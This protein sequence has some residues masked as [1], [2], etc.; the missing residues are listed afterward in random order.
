MKLEAVNVKM[1]LDVDTLNM[2]ADVYKASGRLGERCRENLDQE[3]LQF[4]KSVATYAASTPRTELEDAQKRENFTVRMLNIG[5]FFRLSPLF[6]DAVFKGIVLRRKAVEMLAAAMFDLTLEKAFGLLGKWKEGKNAKGNDQLVKELQEKAEKEYFAE[7]MEDFTGKVAAAVKNAA[8]AVTKAKAELAEVT[9]KL[10]TARRNARHFELKIIEHPPGTPDGVQ[11][12]WYAKWSAYDDAATV[13]QGQQ[14]ELQ[15]VFISARKAA[16]GIDAV[17]KNLAQMADPGSRTLQSW[18]EAFAPGSPGEAL[19]QGIRENCQ[20]ELDQLADLYRAELAAWDSRI[21]NLPLRLQGP[22]REN[23]KKAQDIA[24]GLQRLDAFDAF[25]VDNGKNV[26]SQVLQQ[27]DQKLDEL[28][29]LAQ[30][31]EQLSKEQAGFCYWLWS[32]LWEGL[33]AVG[34]AVGRAVSAVGALLPDWLVTAGK[35]V[36][37]VTAVVT[38]IYYW[39][40]CLMVAGFFILLFLV[41][42]LFQYTAWIFAYLGR[43][44]DPTYLAGEYRAQGQKFMEGYGVPQA[45]FYG[46]MQEEAVKSIVFDADPDNLPEAAVRDKA[47]AQQLRADLFAKHQQQ[48]VRQADEAKDA[49]RAAVLKMCREAL[50]MPPILN[51]DKRALRQQDSAVRGVLGGVLAAMVS[52]ERE[53]MRSQ[54]GFVDFVARKADSLLAGEEDLSWASINQWLNLLGTQ[55]SLFLNGCCACAVRYAPDKVAP[56]V[57]KVAALSM[58]VAIARVLLSMLCVIPCVTAF[59]GDFMAMHGIAFQAMIRETE[60]VPPPDLSVTAPEGFPARLS[61]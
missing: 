34:N 61:G 18:Q 19:W 17:R 5:S 14:A 7:A 3:F 33:A 55:V 59:A 16:E 21:S 42:Q 29:G 45:Y 28:R 57:A 32:V 10:K 46:E 43:W 15:K 9:Q 8:Q 50:L 23:L 26:K 12:Q 35:A 56:F 30:Q 52:Y 2:L 22:A 13:L 51:D 11:L 27:A 25:M 38:A 36:F 6:F 40:V 58:F 1:S 54:D 41:M 44:R 47:A 24:A 31:Q 37:L 48:A 4:S 39:S 53:F 20:R 60:D 49:Y